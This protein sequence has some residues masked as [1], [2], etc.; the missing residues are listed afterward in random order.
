MTHILIVDDED[1]ISSFLAKGLKAAGYVV[2]TAR[3]ARDGLAQAAGA[4]LVILD[5]GLPDADG[6]SVLTQL[7]RRGDDVPVIILTARSSVTDTVTGLESGADDY[8]AK[9]IRFEELLAR[10]RLRLKR[11]A[12]GDDPVTL[13]CGSLTLDLLTRQASVD[14]QTIDLSAREFT[15]IETLLRHA[16]QVLSREQLLA[17]VWGYDYDPGSNVVD[18]YIGYLRRKLGNQRIETVRGMGYRLKAV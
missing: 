4:D 6:F 2:S 17:Q 12:N 15:L 10:V 14:D 7:R 1:R 3:T 11:P 16:G 13:S 8:M 18:V 9:P 5:L